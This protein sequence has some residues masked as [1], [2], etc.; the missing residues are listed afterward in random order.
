MDL[1][2]YQLRMRPFPTTPDVQFYYP[3]A[4]HES[5]LNSLA[6]AIDDQAGLMLLHG[7]PGTGKTLLAHMFLQ[8][9]GPQFNTAL[10][11]NCRF[12]S[13]ADLHRAVLFDLGQPYQKL[14]EE[15]LRI[16]VSDYVLNQFGEG[17]PTVLVFDEAQDLSAWLLEELRLLGNLE[18]GRGKAVQLVLL[19]L[20]SILETLNHPS[21]AA[22]NQ[23]LAQR[24][25]LDPLDM[26]ESADYLLQQIRIA[27]GRAEQTFS[28]EAVS[29]LAKNARG[30]PRLL[31]RYALQ[32]L[33]L[34]GQIDA[35]M[36]DVEVALEALSSLGIDAEIAEEGFPTRPTLASDLAEEEA[37][38]RPKQD[39]P[40]YTPMEIARADSPH[41]T[42]PSTGVF[43]HRSPVR[44]VN[45]EA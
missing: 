42:A 17:R 33:K 6:C 26:H 23:R 40:A 8:R 43:A 45:D 18:V 2:R 13:A 3:A 22:L 31:N 19:A 15:E 28:D 9:L 7:E 41:E 14:G 21:L 25:T 4:S 32:A 29:V 30:V 35:D 24:L 37:E 38:A 20:P 39:R 1:T 5:G 10:I 34:A 12:G 16:A 44:V 36:V 11:T 27:G